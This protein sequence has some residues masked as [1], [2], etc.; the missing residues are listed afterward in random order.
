M[1][2][3]DLPDLTKH[4]RVR[5]ELGRYGAGVQGSASRVRGSAEPAGRSGSPALQPQPRPVGP[6]PPHEGPT[7]YFAACI[8]PVIGIPDALNMHSQACALNQCLVDL[9]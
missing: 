5:A 3:Q 8:L 1:G 6:H 9:H 4:T 7:S 2:I